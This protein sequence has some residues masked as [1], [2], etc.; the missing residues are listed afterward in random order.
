[1]YTGK[2][3]GFRS[4]RYLLQAVAVGFE[5]GVLHRDQIEIVFVGDETDDPWG[6]RLDDYIAQYNLE[7]I[8]LTKPPVSYGDVLRLQSQADVLMVFKG[9]GEVLTGGNMPAKLVDYLGAYKPV[10]A[11]APQ[12]SVIH[13]L[14]AQVGVGVCAEPED[15]EDILKKIVKLVR[16]KGAELVRDETVIRQY[17]RVEQTQRLAELLR[18]VIGESKRKKLK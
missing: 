9:Y 18:D 11:L 4:A 17:S 16:T 1:M 3:G 5:T 7:G 14:V 6:K 12:G 8:V 15:V 2:M 10:L 13:D